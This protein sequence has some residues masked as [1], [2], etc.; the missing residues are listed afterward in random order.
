MDPTRRRLLGAG[1]AV[2]AAWTPIA[3]LAPAAADPG[4]VG[5][6]AGVALYR[7]QFANWSREL[8]VDDLW[9]C[10]PT[11][12]DQLLAVADW[13]A[14]S[15]WRVRARG[16]QHGWS[17][18]LI[19]SDTDRDSHVVLVDTTGLAAIRVL[20]DGRVRA[21]AGATS[22]AVLEAL[23][24]AGRGLVSVPAVG[25]VT[26]GGMLAI[27]AHGAAVP[28]DGEIPHPT[29]SFGSLSGA[30]SEL[31][32]AVWQD[33]R[34]VART[35]TRAD[36]ELR[37]LACSLGRC[38]V[39]EVVLDTVPAYSLRCRSIVDIPSSE[40]F[41]PDR[42]GART[43][44]SFL[45]RAGR[46]EALHSPHTDHN[47]L[48]VWSVAPRQPL[49]TRRTSGPYNYPFSDQIP[50]EIADLAQ[51]LMAGNDAASPVFSNLVWAV[52]SAGLLATASIDLWGPAWHTQLYIQ[53][54]T[55]RARELGIALLTSRARVQGVLHGFF[56][57]FR[58]LERV[59]AD[60][61]LYPMNIPLEIRASGLDGALG[62][63]PTLAA[64]SPDPTAPDLDTVLFINPLTLVGSRGADAFY[65]DL[66]SYLN[67][68]DP[69]V[70]RF[71]PEWSKNFL[72]T[73]HGP[74]MTGDLSGREEATE[75]L[76]ERFRVGR[77]AG[78]RWDDAAAAL[79]R[80]D[81]RGVFTNDF[82]DAL[83]AR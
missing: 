71:R 59:Y 76:R 26:V 19:T 17:P 61:G 13:G 8:V 79:E 66:E 32:A 48:K 53:A 46:L 29:A 68:L 54:T 39:L 51:Q 65:T 56:A 45:R 60:R 58:R 2:A 31:T 41:G 3:R 24:A 75:R 82:H 55:L 15:G 28:A 81:P 64:T 25:D 62:A 49:G 77:P 34:F 1:V 23:H 30:V 44:A 20:P 38:F 43:F 78:D 57:E 14:R 73:P 67:C 69:A 7:Q 12:P 18:F 11:S 21:G 80:L 27:S 42:P 9:T 22:A 35:F 47:W 52:A 33:G 6:P 16:F 83:F 5:F 4:P 74:A 70:A 50:V 37:A 40:L 72:Y 36:P 63:Y 10:R